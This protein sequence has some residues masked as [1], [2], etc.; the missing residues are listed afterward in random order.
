MVRGAYIAVA[1]LLPVGAACS[2]IFVPYRCRRAA[3][4]P[5]GAAQYLL[6]SGVTRTPFAQR[7]EYA[8]EPKKQRIFR[9]E[10]ARKIP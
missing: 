6:S 10:A 8:P 2:D 1:E 3:V 9:C 7:Q 4:L 5:G